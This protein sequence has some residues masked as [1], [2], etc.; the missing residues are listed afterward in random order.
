MRNWYDA[1][2]PGEWARRSFSFLNSGILILTLVLVL[3]EFRFDWCETLVGRYLMS[4]NHSRPETGS[5]WETGRHTV[6]ARQS[7]D[8]ILL[9]KEHL[10]QNV[11][12]V[13]SFV[14][15]GQGLG[16]G[17]WVNLDKDRFRQLY[18][19]LPED[20]RH[21]LIPPARLVW[22]LHSGNTERIFCEGRIGGMIIYFIDAG[23]RVIRQID[24]DLDETA[25]LAHSMAFN[26]RLEDMPGFSGSVYPADRFFDAA[27]K[28]PE[29]MLPDLIRNTDTLFA[30][31]GTIRRVGVWHT[32]EQGYI[33]LGFEFSHLGEDRVVQVRAREW[34]VWQL[35]LILR[36][37]DQ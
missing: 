2:G 16:A 19:S 17:A 12:E 5:I 6:S 1:P 9:Q 23:N 35:G 20:A 21:R 31:T 15:L 24:M 3:A 22:L 25:E 7:L 13:A 18:L 30:G 32:S 26:G 37:E 8:E 27:F 4:T 34:A 33:R 29:N 36:G 14:Q 28:L 11:N 10:R